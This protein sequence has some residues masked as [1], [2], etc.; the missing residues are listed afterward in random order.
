M[1]MPRMDSQS[2][3]DLARH[4]QGATNGRRK[5]WPI[6]PAIQVRKSRSSCDFSYQLVPDPRNIIKNM[7][8]DI[9]LDFWPVSVS[10]YDFRRGPPALL[11]TGPG[12]GATFPGHDSIPRKLLRG[13]FC[14]TVIFLNEPE[15]VSRALT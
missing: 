3:R 11:T 2:L 6:R 7:I 5:L 13:I 12:C 8:Y 4:F 9:S 15:C 14:H 1:A 10:Y